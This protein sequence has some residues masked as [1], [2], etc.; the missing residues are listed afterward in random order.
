LQ[1]LAVVGAK[2]ANFFRQKYF[3]NRNIAP[4]PGYIL[5]DLF[6]VAIMITIF[7][8]FRRQKLAFFSK[9]NV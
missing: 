1:K 3:Y 9:A 6:W 5:G 2:N 4:K 8:D 7:C